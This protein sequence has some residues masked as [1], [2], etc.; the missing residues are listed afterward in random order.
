MEKFIRERDDG[1]LI[2]W[3]EGCGYS[4]AALDMKKGLKAHGHK[5]RTKKI[6]HIGDESAKARFG[7]KLKPFLQR[8]KQHN[9]T[10]PLVFYKG[11]HIGG[12]TELFKKFS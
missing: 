1:I 6:G 12:Y 4:A 11:K 8:S 10:W 5:V 2:F 3:A 9:I 7:E